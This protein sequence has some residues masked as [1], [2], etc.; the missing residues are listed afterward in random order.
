MKCKWRTQISTRKKEVLAATSSNC[1][2]ILKP[3]GYRGPTELERKQTSDV[4]RRGSTL[5]DGKNPPDRITPSSRRGR[6]KWT[7]R[8]QAPSSGRRFTDCK[9]RGLSAFR[10]L[11]G[12]AGRSLRDSRSLRESGAQR[13]GRCLGNR[14]LESSWGTKLKAVFFFWLCRIC[15]FGHR[16]HR[17]KRVSPD[18]NRN[19]DVP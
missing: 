17:K 15:N 12:S 1:G 10:L 2:K 5:S 16:T 9:G 19:F 3:C 4:S 14:A 13:R 6:E 18:E 8:S 7:I 11:F